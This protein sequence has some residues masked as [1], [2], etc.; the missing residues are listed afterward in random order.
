VNKRSDLLKALG[1]FSFGALLTVGCAQPSTN[2]DPGTGGTG[3]PGTAG[4]T[5]VAGSNTGVAG[6]NTG[7]GGSNPQGVAG[8]NPQGAAGSNPQGAAGSTGKGGTTG[9]AG[10][11]PQGAAGSNPQ[12]VAGSNPQGAAGSNPQGAA[13]STGTAGSGSAGSSGTAPPGYW[14]SGSW[15]GC[16]WTGIDNLNMNTTTMPMDFVSR[17]ANST[18]PY[19]IKGSVGPSY[20]AVALLGFNLAEP[21][22]PT[23]SCAYKPVDTTADGPPEVTL[24]GTGIAI[25]F[26]KKTGATLR[27]QIQGKD[28][29]KAGDVGANNRWC[30]TITDAKGPV[31][32]PFSG[33]N[34]KCWDPTLAGNKKYNGEKIDS[35]VFL[36]PGALAATPYDF[37]IGGFATGNDKSVAPPCPACEGGSLQGTIGGSGA[38]DLDFQR[39]KVSA[40]GKSYIIQNNN[41]GNPSGTNQTISYKDNSFKI[42]S[43]TGAGPG[44]GVPA[45][46][47]SIYIGANGDTQNGNF[48]T[49]SDDNLPKQVSAIGSAQTKLTWTGGGGNYNATYDVW[50]SQNK[51]A[52]R[53][54]DGISGFVMV[55][56]YKP[57]QNQPI[58][59]VA[60]T[61]SIAGK[62]WDVWVGKRGG[63]GS[64]SNAPVVSYVAQ[65]GSVSTLSFDLKAFITDA[66][67]SGISSSWY[68]TDVFAG[69]EIWDGNG[70][71]NLGV[72]EFTANVQ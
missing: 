64:N 5:G 30:Y 52:G 48:S 62:T 35:V 43:P 29:G 61:A 24:T 72:T 25:S 63:S 71:T 58:G 22:T 39:V 17:P 41:W 50:F 9:V 67:S 1:V 21:V 7:V 57:G 3:N 65:G 68:L 60:R 69:F 55:W 26:A 11:N 56:L 40:G 34:S 19:C 46:F 54:N 20:D 45:S 16:A 15:H 59:S 70:T 8:S 18:D 6:S 51:P 38:T 37:C 23:L 66:A 4:T 28:G 12:G 42:T 32:A 13:G 47:P 10:S 53:Y 31:F 27:I 2:D 44:G 14:T 36:V 33:F 49:S